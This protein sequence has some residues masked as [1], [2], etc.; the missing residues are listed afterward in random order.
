MLARDPTAIRVAEALRK[1]CGVG[2]GDR[3]LAGVSGGADSTAMLRILAALAGRR[4]WRC[5]LHVI[6]VNHQLRPDAGHDADF[7]ASLCDSLGVPCRIASIDPAAAAGNLEDNARRRRYEAMEREADRIDADWIAVA[8]HAD[9]QL[10]TLIMRIIRGS[11]LRGMRGIAWRRG[12]LI[13]PMLALDGQAIRQFLARFGQAWREDSTNQDMNRWRAAI[14]G[15]VLPVLRELKPDAA[16]KAV[17]TADQLAEAGRAMERIERRLA[18]RLIRRLPDGSA[19]MAREQAAELERWWIGA[20]IRRV[21][22]ELGAESDALGARVME[23]ML[24]AVGDGQGRERIFELAGGV[25]VEMDRA[26][27]RW[28]RA[29]R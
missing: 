21:A 24:A 27:I 18:R 26:E 17:D 25:R 9:D 11:S 20:L 2:E 8:H 16:E 14:R 28:V 7:T 22:M 4:E 10:E 29:A 19:A 1:R 13:R 3:I 12:R 23:P 5:D 15:R 6:H